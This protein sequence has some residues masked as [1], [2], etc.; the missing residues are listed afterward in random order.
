MAKSGKKWLR[1][2]KSGESGKSGDK[3]GI[4]GNSGEKW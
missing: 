4:V 3:W 2:W 1:V